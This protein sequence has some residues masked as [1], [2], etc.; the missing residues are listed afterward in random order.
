MLNQRN[1]TARDLV[2]PWGADKRHVQRL[3]LSQLREVNTF[4]PSH[5]SVTSIV[6]DVVFNAYF[7]LKVDV[8]ID[9]QSSI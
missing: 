9:L 3:L 7:V 6:I 5:V 4:F 1:I 2:L 8:A